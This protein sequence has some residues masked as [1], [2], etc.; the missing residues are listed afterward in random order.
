MI[1]LRQFMKRD[2]VVCCFRKRAL[3]L[4]LPETLLRQVRERTGRIG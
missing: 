4:C 2:Q 1:P 3:L